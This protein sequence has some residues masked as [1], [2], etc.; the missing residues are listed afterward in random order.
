MLGLQRETASEAKRSEYQG[1]PF[2]F[3]L[4]AR[5]PLALAGFEADLLAGV[6]GWRMAVD[7]HC[8]LVALNSEGDS[9]RRGGVEVEQLVGNLFIFFN[10][11]DAEL[12]LLQGDGSEPLASTPINYFTR[13]AHHA[14][15]AAGRDD[16]AAHVGHDL[17]R[18]DDQR[19]RAQATLGEVA[20]S[21]WDELFLLCG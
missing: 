17:P 15:L 3:D 12:D 13:A 2:F 16:A 20:G 14:L 9:P 18:E 19:R 6:L 5:E 7:Q 4:R 21:D 1:V 10:F 11:A 8:Q